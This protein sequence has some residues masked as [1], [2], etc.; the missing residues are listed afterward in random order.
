MFVFCF[1]KER[2]ALFL[3][4][5][6]VF[7]SLFS[8]PIFSK[9]QVN[10]IRFGEHADKTRI[11]IEVNNKIN[12]SA[13]LLANP[14]RLVV[15]LPAVTWNLPE[16]VE[17]RN[18]GFIKSYRFG[19]FKKGV[20][21][22]VFDLSTT[23][24]LVSSFALDR[25][26]T[27]N[28]FRLVL[29]LE[30]ISAE[31][32]EN[33]LSIAKEQN[34]V[35]REVVKPVDVSEVKKSTSKKWL[36]VI[37]P[38]HGGIDPGAT[39]PNNKLEKTLT[40]IFAKKLQKKLE[41]DQRFQVLL[42]RSSDVFVGLRKRVKI[43]RE[44]RA[45]LFISLHVDSIKNK[46]HRGISIYT[47]SE[48]AS[49]KEAALLAKRENKSDIIAGLDLS[50]ESSE[51][52][53]IL[54]DL[55]KRDTMNSSAELAKFLLDRLAPKFRLIRK[56]HRFAGFAVLKAIDMPSVLIELG[57][58]SNKEDEKNLLSTNYQDNLVTALTKSIQNFLSSQSK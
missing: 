29:D 22:L 19:L 45:D 15:D 16:D 40:L 23:V 27:S 24:R 17:S 41:A 58:L 8:S 39:S 10:N 48:K 14:T 2:T 9:T 51:V 57:Y 53:D 12:F 46:R 3:V 55:A 49:D 54:I 1:Y 11:V 47:L 50:Q 18:Y 36:V 5:I 43:A 35:I 26:G 37:D 38:G 20:S 52:T 25:D 30:R 33:N 28:M 7:I 34:P 44:A 4:L 21:R 42:T 31:E 13:F 6:T 56:S 32:F